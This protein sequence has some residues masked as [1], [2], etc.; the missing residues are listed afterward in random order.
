MDNRVHFKL[1]VSFFMV[2][3]VVKHGQ[4]IRANMHVE[5]AVNN[6]QPLSINSFFKSLI[7]SKSVIYPKDIYP[8]IIIGITI[9]LAGKPRMKAMIITPSNPID[10]AKGSK[11]LVQILKRL[12]SPIIIFAISQITSPAGADITIAL[13]RTNIV[14]SSIDLIITFPI[15]GFLYGG[16]SKVNEEDSPFRI[17]FERSFDIINVIIIPSKIISVKNMELVKELELL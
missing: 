8:M 17:V 14:L 1:P 4:C 7:L 5:I 13:R 15:W 11:V 16:S 12:L 3:T 2:R 9:S 6:V 10:L